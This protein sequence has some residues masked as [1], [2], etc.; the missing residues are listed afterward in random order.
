MADSLTVVAII[1]TYNEEDIIGACLEHL[2][3]QGVQSYLIDDGSTDGTVRE[4]THFIGRGLL[5]V[6]QLPSLGVPTF[7]LDRILARKEE[8]AGQLDAAWFIN[9]DADEFRES[10]W[11]ELDLRGAIEQV[12]ALGWN[13]IDFQIFTM[14]PVGNRI[15][16]S[17]RPEAG[18]SWFELG[19]LCDRLQVRCWKRTTQPVDLRTS[20]GHDVQFSNRRVFP[21]RFPMRH[22]PIRSQ[23]H[24]ERK[25]FLERLPRF[26][27]R[28]RDRGWHVQYKTA[29]RLALRSLPHPRQ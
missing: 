3:G 5:G 21:L 27:P 23:A 20:G 28:E 24:G 10:L 22:Y 25:L 7:N 26:D 15:S 8:L 11:A 6:E 2:C 4:A 9:H 19:A 12:D 16:A 13:A 14:R 18:D 29:S 17:A 1:A